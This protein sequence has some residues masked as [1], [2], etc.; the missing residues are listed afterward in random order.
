M[1]KIATLL[2]ALALIALAT[3]SFAQDKPAKEKT[4][5][6]EAKCAKCM[7]HKSDKCQT[8]VEVPRKDGKKTTYWLVDNETAKSFHADVCHEAKKVTVTGTEKTVDGK[9]ELTA[10]KIEPVKDKSS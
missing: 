6:G 3:P 1:K 4:I 7:L 8:V 9:H 10:T 2:A 5:T